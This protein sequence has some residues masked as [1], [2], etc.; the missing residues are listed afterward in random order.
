[1]AKQADQLPVLVV[2]GT[3]REARLA[4]GRGRGLI[5]LAGGGDADA[6]AR[7]IDAR[8]A[9]H[10]GIAGIISYG[11]AGSLMRGV[12]VGDVV[13]GTEV[14]GS[15]ETPCDADWVAALAAQLP[16]ARR[17]I[18][19]ADGRLLATRGAKSKVGSSSPA[20]CVDME[21]QVAAA[22]ALRHGVPLA[23]LRVIS[24]PHNVSLPPAVEVA[25]GEGGGLAVGAMLGSL[26]R[27]P[28]QLFA[29]IRT[30]RQFARGFASLRKATRRLEAR[31]AFD[32]RGEE[33][34]LPP[35]RYRKRRRLP[36]AL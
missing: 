13:I 1:M 22:A 36:A 3:R 20:A 31:L 8:V 17:A 4:R 7:A 29:L 6:L 23:V 14:D 9:R 33:A 21:S 35:P 16:G 34:P 32:R 19:Y 25:M 27:Q 24:D 30:L 5:V 28:G 26:L 2:T 18:V 11:M 12:L 15:V 10:G